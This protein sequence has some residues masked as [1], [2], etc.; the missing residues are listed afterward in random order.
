MQVSTPRRSRQG[1]L[2]LM[3]LMISMTIGLVLLTGL[4]TYFVNASNSQRELQR[5]A[6]QIENGRYALD[7]LTQDLH[8][9]GFYGAYYSFTAPT[10]LPDPCDTAAASLQ[11]AMGLPVQG[12]QA[13]DTTSKP[14]PS[15]ACATLL[16]SAN[17]AA[18]SDIVVIRY[19][20]PG[21]VSMG[22]TTLATETYLQSNSVSASIQ[23]GGGTVGCT[24]TAS[25]TAATITRKCKVP[26]SSDVCTATCTGGGSPAAE[27][28]KYYVHIYFVAPCS[29][30]ASGSACTGSS[31]DGGTPIPTLK[32]LELTTSG[33]SIVPVAEG[34]EYMKIEYGV[35][36]S[37]TTTNSNTGL[38][39]D[40]V[41]DSYVLTPTLTD[42]ANAVSVRVDLLVRNTSLTPG[43]SSAKTYNLGINPVVTT[44]PAVTL[45]PFTD[46]YRR[47]VYAAET[48]LVNL[49]GRKE[50]P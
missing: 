33:F 43:Y 17:L 49:S 47:H 35:D 45:G 32:R 2:S 36:N 1:G 15:T 14:T 41:P 31:D 50:N 29:V 5:S 11:G 34:V 8:L 13:A 16:T 18:G 46:S 4:V 38:I 19:A 6:Q 26:N 9:A 25:G 21:A 37:P 39:G 24:T 7:T 23:A 3:E 44:S 12:Y 28:R 22:A 42:F 48:R 30:P 20:E 10:A 40:G 27:L